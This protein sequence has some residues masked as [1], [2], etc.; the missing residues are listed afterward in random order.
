M[1]KCERP[2]G[3]P[4]GLGEDRHSW[5]PEVSQRG[6]SQREALDRVVAAVPALEHGCVYGLVRSHVSHDGF[7]ATLPSLPLSSDE[8]G[9]GR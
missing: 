2:G 4:S 6:H 7:P 1:F 8:V 3:A 5:G 9:A